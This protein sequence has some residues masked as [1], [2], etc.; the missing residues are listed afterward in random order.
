MT[1]IHTG[2]E[3]PNLDTATICFNAHPTSPI[4][5]LISLITVT[6]QNHCVCSDVDTLDWPVLAFNW[7][8]LRIWVYR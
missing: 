2:F 4:A 6:M 8:N 5:L 7:L 1:V 3:P